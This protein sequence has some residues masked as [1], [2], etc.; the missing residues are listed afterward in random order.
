VVAENAATLSFGAATFKGLSLNGTSKASIAKSGTSTLVV[1]AL[2]LSSTATL[3]LNDNG[4]VVRNG[5]LTALQDL[6]KSARMDD[7]TW[8]GP[9]ITTTEA[10]SGPYPGVTGV[11]LIQNDYGGGAGVVWDQWRGATVGTSDVLLA[12][13][14]LGDAN[15]DGQLEAF[16]FALLDAGFTGAGSGWLYGDFDMGGGPVDD[17]DFA[18]LDAGFSGSRDPSD[19][20]L[21]LSIALFDPAEGSAGGQAVAEDEEEAPAL[22]AAPLVSGSVAAVVAAPASESA[23]PAA[24][25]G[26]VFNSSQ[27]IEDGVFEDEDLFQAFS[28]DEINELLA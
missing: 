23:A 26:S 3:D 19:P 12:Y 24:A 4:L 21:E 16:D 11:G 7:F 22:E 10:V 2:S 18:L 15:L 27:A 25:S 28:E 8:G 1:G 17:F 5:N 13:T 6:V 14:W 9:G 20:T